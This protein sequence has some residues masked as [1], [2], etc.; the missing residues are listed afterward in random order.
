MNQTVLNE[1]A[2]YS[3]ELLTDYLES[4]SAEYIYKY[5]RAKER[6]YLTNKK[7]PGFSIIDLILQVL[8]ED[9]NISLD[10]R[11]D[12]CLEFRFNLPDSHLIMNITYSDIDGM[13]CISAVYPFLYKDEYMLP[14]ID[15]ISRCNSSSEIMPLGK[16]L[17]KRK[18]HLIAFENQYICKSSQDF[19]KDDFLTYL[20]ATVVSAG[21]LYGEI[22]KYA[23]IENGGE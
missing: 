21:R 5:K 22:S 6:H 11:K 1:S 9:L 8:E 16:I 15:L 10:N 2:S 3:T 13:V 19:K 7:K 4:Q 20:S 18:V 23:T 14:L 17:L 12:G